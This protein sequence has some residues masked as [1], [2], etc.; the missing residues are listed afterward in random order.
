[1]EKTARNINKV[2]HFIVYCS[3]LRRE[4]ATCRPYLDEAMISNITLVS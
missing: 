3:I 1:M 2:K 4:A